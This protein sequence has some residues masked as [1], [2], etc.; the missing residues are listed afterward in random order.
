MISFREAHTPM[1]GP[2]GG[3]GGRGGAVIFVANPSVKSLL[4][5]R[6]M[7]K[8]PDGTNGHGQNCHGKNGKNIVISVCASL[9]A[10][11]VSINVV[12]FQVPLG[13]IFKVNGELVA[14]LANPGDRHTA[15]RGGKGG[16]G[17]IAFV[18]P[19]NQAPLRNT[20]GTEGD[21]WTIEV[22]LKTI[23]D[24]GLVGVC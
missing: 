22:E 12:H 5:M 6:N 9:N 3:D 23:A 15:A 8:A 21:N 13:T 14:D 2:D 18:S 24:I 20:A 1:G 16:N 17:N 7:Y 4:N 10:L 19:T 11:Y